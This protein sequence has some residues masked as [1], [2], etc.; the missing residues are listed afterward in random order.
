[1]WSENS[2]MLILVQKT[3]LYISETKRTPRK[4]SWESDGYPDRGFQLLRLPRCENDHPLS[5]FA[6]F[7]RVGKLAPYF[8][9]EFC[10]LTQFSS[11]GFWIW[12][13]LQSSETRVMAQ[14]FSGLAACGAWSCFDLL[15]SYADMFYFV[16]SVNS[17]L[18]I[19]LDD[20]APGLVQLLHFNLKSTLN[21]RGDEFNRIGVEVLSVIAQQ[22]MCTLLS[23]CI[24]YEFST[25]LVWT[26]CIFPSIRSISLS[27][28]KTH[29]ALLETRSNSEK[30]RASWSIWKRTKRNWSLKD[31]YSTR[32][33]SSWNKIITDQILTEYTVSSVTPFLVLFPAVR[34]KNWEH[35]QCAVVFNAVVHYRV[36]PINIY[37]L[38]VLTVFYYHQVSLHIPVSNPYTQ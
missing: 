34:G 13:L 16:H 24:V 4:G 25:D 35:T 30:R 9:N 37:S 8:G 3:Q 19:A 14:F 29:M 15:S 6:I 32:L 12:P 33:V 23:T 17:V 18:P 31:A 36:L 7:W 5:R 21:F 2:Y 11:D 38:F 22:M 28:L 26:D 1:M 10:A 27:H 20:S